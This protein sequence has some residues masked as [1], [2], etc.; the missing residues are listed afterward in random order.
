MVTTIRT[1]VVDREEEEEAMVAIAATI[2]V[3]IL[4]RSPKKNA[5][6]L[7]VVS[8]SETHEKREGKNKTEQFTSVP[9]FHLAKGAKKAQ[10]TEHGALPP[11]PGLAPRSC[12]LARR[13]AQQQEKKTVQSPLLP[14]PAGAPHRRGACVLWFDRHSRATARCGAAR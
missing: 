13:S 11:V 10:L 7:E 5:I 2:L 6:V 9:V 3:G 1:A 14:R 4:W 8:Q 12:G